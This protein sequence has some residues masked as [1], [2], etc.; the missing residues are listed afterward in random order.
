MKLN[1]SK[2]IPLDKFIDNFLYN[3]KIG[4]YMN[5]NP[6]GKNGDFI[7]APNISVLF[8]EMVAIWCIAFWENLGCPKKINI[9]ELGAGNGEMMH[10][11]IK[12][13]E[14]FHKFKT[15][16]EYFILE[17]SLFLKKI[18]RKKLSFRKIT[19]L[20]SLN[21]LQDG[22]NIFLANEFFDS[23]PIK[24]FIKKNKRWFEKKVKT[25]NTED[26]ELIDTLTNIKK[27]EKKIG[28]NLSNDQ[29]IIEF[30]PLSYKYL[31][32]ISKKINTFKGGLLI[33]D[34]GYLEKKMKNSL[35]SV[36]K[37]KFNNI[38]KNLGKSDITYNINFYLL[39][40]ITK[41]LNLKVAG[42]TNQKSFL[43]KLGIMQRAEIIA[44]NLKFSK[45]ADIYYRLNRLI[46]NKLMGDLFKVMFITKKNNKFKIGFE[47]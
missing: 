11:M 25:T 20:N 38:L 9:V 4:Y 14:R 5:N 12:V 34:Y 41:K 46:D 43:T 7:T 18:Q 30:S 33:I 39:K 17:K 23:L 8:S 31:N 13:F 44:R 45:K 40:K 24:Q 36:Y 3:K 1:K 35:Q 22:P 37:H 10:H 16:S 32:I 15:S 21:K 28:I 29:K 6:F 42:L 19:W 47:N 26:F 2:Y 27:L